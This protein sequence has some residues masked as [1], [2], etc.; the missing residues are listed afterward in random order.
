MEKVI[1][2]L[3]DNKIFYLATVDGDKPK[4]RPFG[5]VLNING[6]INI[7]TGS[8]KDVFKQIQENPNVEISATGEDGAFLRLYGKVS[9]NTSSETRQNFFD[10]MPSLRELYDKKEDSFEILSFDAG[11]TA[12]FQNMK[13]EKEIIQL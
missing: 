7:C 10:A 8:W 4:V 13:G 6:K 5:A 3:Q 9:S 12:I 2:F 11:A 1:K